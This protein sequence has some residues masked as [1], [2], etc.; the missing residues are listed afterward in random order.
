M[1]LGSSGFVGAAL[2]PALRAAGL[3]TMGLGSADLDLRWQRNADQLAPALGRDSVVVFAARARQ[4]QHSWLAFDEDAAM[5][6]NLARALA[7]APVR[8]CIYFSSLSV[9]GEAE[10]DLDLTEESA[11]APLTPYAVARYAGERLLWAAAEQA[12]FDLVVLR[13]CKLYGPGETSPAY[14]PNGFIDAILRT[15]KVTVYGD[16]SELRDHLF[17]PDLVRLTARF[18]LERSRGTFN[19]ASGES[20][21]FQ[22]ILRLLRR[23]LGREFEVEWRP[24]TRPRID[25]RVNI[26]KLRSALPDL[27]FTPLEQGLR[28]TYDYYAEKA[29]TEVTW[30]KST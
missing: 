13:L 20:C 30:R 3:D 1:V 10:S 8:K 27:A 9:Y 28:E 18:A 15:G 21:S 5:A 25:Q 29:A 14:G 6:A 4:P 2:L 24:R 17:V 16:G 26:H 11:V 19:V 12:G 22:D 23:I 7:A